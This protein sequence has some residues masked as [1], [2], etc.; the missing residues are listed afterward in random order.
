MPK[1]VLA[2]YNWKN[3]G[4]LIA[5]IARV[6]WLKRNLLTLDPTFGKGVWWSQWR[7][8]HLFDHDLK[9]DGHDFRE[10]SYDDGTF[11][12]IAFDPP[13]VSTGGR[14]TTTIA[15]FYERY[16]L[17]GAPTSPAKLQTLINDGITEMARLIERRGILIVKS[18]DY[19]SSGHLWPGT[20]LMQEHA[21]MVGFKQVDRFIHYGSP[22]AQPKRTRRDGKPV[23]QKHA[24]ANFSIMHVFQKAAA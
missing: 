21:R 17:T 5:D 13:Y 4:Y 7:P 14:A 6:G 22:R 11:P 19:V 12:Q 10:L 3:N 16:G 15:E 20:F 9:I 8:R 24:R 18:M 2:A 1:P 23:R